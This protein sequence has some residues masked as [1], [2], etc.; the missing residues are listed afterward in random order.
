MGTLV[1]AAGGC[2]PPR[3]SSS[4]LSNAFLMAS[5]RF[6]PLLTIVSCALPDILYTP[7]S[8][9]RA[10]PKIGLLLSILFRLSKTKIDEITPITLSGM[11]SS[12]NHQK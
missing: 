12:H 2:P 10:I 11:I 7:S 5:D 1:P 3:A 6:T 9:L 8:S 4:D